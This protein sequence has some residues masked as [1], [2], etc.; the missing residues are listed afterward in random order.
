M[1]AVPKTLLAT[2]V[3]TLLLLV[4]MSSLL[5]A[6]PQ[7]NKKLSWAGCGISKSAFMGEMAAAYEKKTGIKIDLIGGGATKGIRQV[8]SQQPTLAAH[9]GM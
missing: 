8:S 1:N 9:V 3:S 7:D 2:A 5:A 4:N 6:T